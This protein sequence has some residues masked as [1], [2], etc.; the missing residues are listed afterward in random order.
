MAKNQY[1]F[2]SKRY[3][4]PVRYELIFSNWCGV[5][6]SVKNEKTTTYYL[7]AVPS[8]LAFNKQG[9]YIDHYELTWQDVDCRRPIGGHYKTQ[10]AAIEMLEQ[11]L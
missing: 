5:Y 8:Y 2:I 7:E 3:R 9:A 4:Q 6:H 10:K 1:G 11:Y